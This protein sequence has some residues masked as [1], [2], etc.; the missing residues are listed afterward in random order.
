MAISGLQRNAQCANQHRAWSCAPFQVLLMT[1]KRVS[2][3]RVEP[4]DSIIA[5]DNL[6]DDLGKSQPQSSIKT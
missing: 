1:E 3:L 5:C 2:V 4:A 6:A